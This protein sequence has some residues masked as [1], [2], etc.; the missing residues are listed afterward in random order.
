METDPVEEAADVR[1]KI[2]KSL[3]RS[4]SLVRLM[5]GGFAVTILLV[6]LTLGGIVHIALDTN[7]AV[8]RQVLPLQKR[9]AELED[10]NAQL[11]DVNGQAV[12]WI[13]KLSHQIEALGAKPPEIV[14]RPTT[15]TTAPDG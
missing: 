7:D 5:V 11:E 10:T 4:V 2:A 3:H 1:R 12:D 8:E 9:N 13:V 15:T 14:I 6:L